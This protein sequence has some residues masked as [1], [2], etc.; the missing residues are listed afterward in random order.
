MLTK[1]INRLSR[2]FDQPLMSYAQC[3]ED[4][5]INFVLEQLGRSKPSYLDIGAHHASYLSNTYFFYKKGAV[6]VCVEPDPLLCENIKRKRKK[7]KCLNIGIGVNQADKDAPFYVLSVK[8]LSTFSKI[9]AE[10]YASYGNHKIDKVLNIPLVTVNDVIKNN[11]S[12]C[13]DFISL[14][15]EGWDMQILKSLD[16]SQYRP[17]VFC[18]ETLTYTENKSERKITEIIDYMLSQNYFLYADTYIN[19]IFVDSETWAKR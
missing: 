9:E 16:F 12:N 18:I 11:F 15:V 7:D 13:P 17:P 3:G 1:I 6:G 4:I 2:G 10:R 8:T 14:D 19:S 5:I